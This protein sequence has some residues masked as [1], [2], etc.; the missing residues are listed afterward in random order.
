MNKNIIIN[1]IL[2]KTFKYSGLKY[3]YFKNKKNKKKCPILL[4]HSLNPNIDGVPESLFKEHVQYLSLNY[5]LITLKDAI[6]RITY[7]HLKG[8]ELVITLDDGYEDNFTKALPILIKYNATATIFI[9]TELIGKKYLEQ[10][11]LN[12]N[13]II[14][15]NRRGMEIGSHTITH[16]N[17]TT[18]SENQLK[19]ELEQS[20]R[21]LEKIIKTDVTSFSYPTGF[22]NKA[23]IE[24]CKKAEY[25]AACT[26]F[27]NFYIDLEKIYEIPRIV[28]YSYD[29]VMDLQAKI[30]GDHHWMTILDKL[31]LPWI[32]KKYDLHFKNKDKQA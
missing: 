17:L 4:Y 19:I 27:Y 15:L 13:Q 26:L 20:K 23:V 16:P 6:Q 3:F 24:I 28:I 5:N 18:I 2:D 25:K 22:Y 10:K 21:K 32:L 7:G 11:M 31:F 30:N 29:S 14:E 1:R 8:D 12:E 9:T